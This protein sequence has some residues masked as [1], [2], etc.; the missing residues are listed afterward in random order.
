MPEIR[1]REERRFVTLLD[2]HFLWYLLANVENEAQNKR[3]QKNSENIHTIFFFFKYK[4]GWEGSS[5]KRELISMKTRMTTAKGREGL[6]H[7]SESQVLFCKLRPG[8]AFWPWPVS[9]EARTVVPSAPWSACRP[10]EWSVVWLLLL[11]PGALVWIDPL[12][13]NSVTGYL[14]IAS[15]KL[16][17]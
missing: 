15:N 7:T 10:C 11:V 3:M 13:S 1:E 6:H 14:L 4:W 2:L 17:T 12:T 8:P 16:S 5:L 9:W